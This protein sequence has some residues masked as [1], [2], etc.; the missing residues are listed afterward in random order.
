[1]T[2]IASGTGG[3]SLRKTGSRPRLTSWNADTERPW[4]ADADG[5]SFED[6]DTTGL[7]CMCPLVSFANPAGLGGLRNVVIGI[8]LPSTEIHNG[9]EDGVRMESAAGVF[10]NR[11]SLG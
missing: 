8:E 3:R 7:T 4:F 11:G 1:M 9:I 2:S 10:R 5:R 6:I